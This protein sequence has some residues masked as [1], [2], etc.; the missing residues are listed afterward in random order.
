VRGACF[1]RRAGRALRGE[2]IARVARDANRINQRY[3][4]IAMIGENRTLALKAGFAVVGIE[5]RF[6]F[7]F[8]LLVFLMPQARKLFPAPGERAM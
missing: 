1:G 5:S 6:H 2:Q 3:G 7:E 4:I 8:P